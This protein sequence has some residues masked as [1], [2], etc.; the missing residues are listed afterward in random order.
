MCGI[1]GWIDFKRNFPEQERLIETMTDSL[2][3]RGPDASGTWLGEHVALGHRRLSI[4]DLALGAQPMHATGR[5]GR[6]AVVSFCGEIYNF[7]EL[8]DEL[9]R[10]GY[11]FETNSDTEVL[12]KGYLHWQEEIA[13]HL[14]GMFAVGIWDGRRER[15]VLIRDR[16]G[17]KPLYYA[18]TDGGL[19]F[20][21][22][23]KALFRHPL[24]KPRVTRDGMR[25]L[26]DMIK[27]P[28][29]TVYDGV[30]EVRPGDLV[31][32][33]RTGLRKQTY[34]RLEARA[35]R[36]DR[37]TTVETVRE[38]L[39]DTV[40]RQIV[41]DVPICTLL[42]GGLDSSAVT[43]IAAR[44]MGAGSLSSYSVDFQ[45]NVDA[46]TVD[47]VRGSP[48]APFARDLAAHASTRHTELLLRSDQMLADP[49]R[50]SILNAVDAPPAYW[51]DMWP[52]LYLLFR[53]LSDHS[54][55]ALSG[56]A[57]D[58]VFGG[59][60][61]FRN[62]AALKA[63]T[64]P[65]LTAGSSRYFGGIQL[66]APDFVGS[67]ERDAYRAERYREA[68][69]EVPVLD[70]EAEQD[71]RL[72]EV[73]YL[74]LTRFLQTL[75]D[76]NDRMS[77]AV[78][79]EVRVPFCD[80]RL[81]EYVFN[82]PWEMKTFDGRDKSLLREAARPLL[83]DSVLNRVKTPYPATQDGAYEQGLRAEL[84]EVLDDAS[85]PVHDLL[86]RAKVAALLERAPAEISQP[87]NRGGLEMVLWMNRWIKR[88]DVELAL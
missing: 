42:S 77:M 33:D 11:A 45:H 51:G 78:G 5:D 40:H 47:G 20:A 35:H 4:I 15:L 50:D 14:N 65:W 39:A 70:G 71:R 63:E 76:R 68:L 49:V 48:D 21:S 1:T 61:W 87:Y 32:L 7:K 54:T 23:P 29:L 46:F 64:F 10:A 69:E 19:V 16:L 74:A 3:H 17:V 13:R 59:Y 53:E 75:L 36:D 8:R 30:F 73:S 88:Y 55:V 43:A 60:Q 85:A 37:Q 41:S 84:M 31:I 28:E 57:A 72:R 2:V 22:E 12:V 81:V 86:D 6:T 38:L 34:W 56:E 67:L 79:V 66:L 18:P 62:P 52:S 44:R 58:E 27:T 26:L 83:P 24:V 80:H 25:E 82:V 9:R